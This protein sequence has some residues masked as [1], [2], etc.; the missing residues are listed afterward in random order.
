M[1]EIH[2]G[3]KM[4]WSEIHQRYEVSLDNDGI[5]WEE[6][7]KEKYYI[8]FNMFDPIPKDVS[9]GTKKYRMKNRK[10]EVLNIF[11]FLLNMTDE[12]LEKINII[13]RDEHWYPLP[14]ET[15]GSNVR[16][17]IRKSNYLRKALK[18]VK[19][20]LK[21]K[22]HKTLRYTPELDPDVVERLWFKPTYGEYEICND[23]DYDAIHGPGAGALKNESEERL[24]AIVK[25]TKHPYYKVAKMLIKDYYHGTGLKREAVI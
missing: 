2:K 1:S 19:P 3:R 11:Y 20:H 22:F 23:K 5:P 9:E 15:D 24:E 6:T 12:D 8:Y 4:V 18:S 7:E 21:D 14:P 16:I 25:N 13:A 10:L 17:Q